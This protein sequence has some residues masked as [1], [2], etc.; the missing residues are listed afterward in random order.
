MPLLP[1]YHETASAFLGLSLASKGRSK[2][3]YQEIGA[4]IG[5]Q[6]IVEG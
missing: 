2:H 1:A 4:I 3:R 5:N 6:V